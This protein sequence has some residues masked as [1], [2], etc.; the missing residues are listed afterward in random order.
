MKKNVSL[1]FV[2]LVSIVYLPAL[3]GQIFQLSGTVTDNSYQPIYEAWIDIYSEGIPNCYQTGVDGQYGG[4]NIW[5]NTIDIVC[6]KQGYQTVSIT[7]HPSTQENI[8]DFRLTRITSSTSPTPSST[9]FPSPTPSSTTIPSP[10][11]SS[12]TLSSPTPSSTIFPSPTP[13]PSPPFKLI[14]ILGIHDY[15]GDGTADVAI[16]RPSTGLWAVRDITRFYY[17]NSDDIPISEYYSGNVTPDFAVF[18]RNIGLWAIRD[19]TR[20]YFGSSSDIPVP[21]DYNAD[22]Y[23][24]IGIFRDTSG[25]WAVRDITRVYFGS[26]GDIPH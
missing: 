20:I 21:G 11:P 5:A 24:D 3:F 4:W 10:T 1:L 8:I 17:G 22:G 23:C 25:L 6:S 19:F 2:I 26:T 13:V 12:T 15:N 18:R 9:I 16:F 7:V 14:P